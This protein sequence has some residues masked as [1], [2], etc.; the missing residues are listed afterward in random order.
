MRHLHE[1]DIFIEGVKNYFHHLKGGGDG[2]SVGTPYLAK[3]E[4][5]L[6]FDYTGMIRVSG[7]SKG[8][9]F[10]SASTVMLKYILLSHEE[11]NFNDEIISDIAGEIANTI[12]GNARRHL[13]SGF[14]ISSPRVLKKEIKRNLYAETARSYV[15]PIRWRN[16]NARLIVSLENS[17]YP[18]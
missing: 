7:D 11:S 17:Q 5:N 14:H 10:F 6:G 3:T 1:I 13:G 9:V 12:A 2:F 15:L 18:D 4:E 16:N 8:V